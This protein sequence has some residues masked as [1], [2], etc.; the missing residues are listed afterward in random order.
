MVRNEKN[1]RLYLTAGK[2]RDVTKLSEPSKMRTGTT[3]HVP[4]LESGVRSAW[5]L[6]P[7]M[8]DAEHL[9]VWSFFSLPMF[10][11]NYFNEYS[12]GK[13]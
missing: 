12:P 4:N 1:T 7:H 5:I 13:P 8:T 10:E 11:G 3:A 9:T 2:S 6:C